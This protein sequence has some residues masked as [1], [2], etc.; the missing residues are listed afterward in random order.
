MKK[1]IIS[2]SL[3]SKNKEAVAYTEEEAIKRYGKWF[4]AEEPGFME[5]VARYLTATSSY[6]SFRVETE[7][8]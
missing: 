4:K 5:R 1:V 3:L 8:E 7:E 2:K 6:D